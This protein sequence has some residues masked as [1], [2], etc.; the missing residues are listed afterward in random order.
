MTRITEEQKHWQHRVHTLG[1][2]EAV[3][4]FLRDRLLREDCREKVVKLIGRLSK[5][6]P[7]H[8]ILEL[9]RSNP[10]W[11]EQVEALL[12]ELPEV[13]AEPTIH[14]TFRGG[15]NVPMS[16]ELDEGR[17]F[18]GSGENY[19]SLDAENGRITWQLQN[20]GRSW[21][22]S[23]LSETSLYVCTGGSLYALSPVDGSELWRYQ[24]EKALSSPY[25]FEDHVFVGSEE[26]TLYAVKARSGVRLW[27]FNV[28]RSVFVAPGIWKSM[29]FAASKD[30]H[31]Y[32]IRITDGECIWRF[33]TGGK[34][35][36]YP[37]VAEGVVYLASSD[38]RL[39]ALLATSGQLLWSFS[40][41]GEIHA[42]PV[43][44]DGVVYLCSRDGH[45]YAISAED[46]KEI[47]RHRTLGY[48]SSPSVGHGMVYFSAQGRVY[49]L[50][51]EDHKLRWCF[52]SGT[53]VATPPVVGNKRVYIGT[54]SG[55]LI[56][57]KLKTKLDEQGATIALKRFMNDE[58]S[59]DVS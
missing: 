10:L 37:Y 34:I 38:H 20:P 49:G 24:V 54:L 16:P 48:P 53:A 1:F 4:W 11:R 39:Y 55:K 51:V 58:F 46:G 22:R 32:G 44:K 25:C 33:A 6:D 7:Q 36:A 19:Y 14:F 23:W 8:E 41:G 35:Y 50:S 59:P 18:F 47:W 15:G 52:P 28:A 2:R 45:L 42:S 26:G 29:I 9:L 17:L 13:N 57:L 56:C 3:L 27:T 30:H 43:E 21:T 31:L 5:Y 40:T 12:L